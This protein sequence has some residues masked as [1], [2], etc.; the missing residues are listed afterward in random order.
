MVRGAPSHTRL[1]P[2]KVFPSRRWPI[3]S[4]DTFRPIEPR[5]SPFTWKGHMR[6]VTTFCVSD[7]SPMDTFFFKVTYLSMLLTPSPVPRF[8]HFGIAIVPALNILMRLE[9]SEIG[10]S[11]VIL[12]AA[13]TM[14]ARPSNFL[15]RYTVIL[16]TAVICG[17]PSDAC[18][19]GPCL[20]SFHRV[21]GTANKCSFIIKA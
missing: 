20:S 6:P 17:Q 16:A 7:S 15:V 19:A 5:R 3:E 12:Q 21:I 1:T 13:L 11:S 10:F 9:K 8:L 14:H 2:V 18:F 4:R